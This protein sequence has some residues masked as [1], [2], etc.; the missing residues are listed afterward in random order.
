MVNEMARDLFHPDIVQP[1]WRSNAGLLV[2]DFCSDNAMQ[3]EGGMVV[4][5]QPYREGT[6]PAAL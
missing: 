3:L 2:Q 4:S 6:T 1:R 5:P